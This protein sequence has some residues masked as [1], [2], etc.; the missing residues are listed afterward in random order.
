[1][2]Y[3]IIIH[4]QD[5]PRNEEPAWKGMAER[6]AADSYVDSTVFADSLAQ[7]IVGQAPQRSTDEERRLLM[8]AD[9]ALRNKD[10]TRLLANSAENLNKV[11]RFF[12]DVQE[13]GLALQHGKWGR[14]VYKM[15]E[16]FDVL[17]SYCSKK[18]AK[19]IFNLVIYAEMPASSA[20]GYMNFHTFVKLMV[21]LAV[22][23]LSN[24]PF[25]TL[26]QTSKV[27][28]DKYI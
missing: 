18:D 15:L 3:T 22:F 17:P 9:E 26:Y 4:H 28:S 6:T 25:S 1:M 13:E 20:R 2:L 8:V 5:F 10:V 16:E 24:P 21:T 11:F 19:T 12:F 23:C 7:G 14:G 27:C